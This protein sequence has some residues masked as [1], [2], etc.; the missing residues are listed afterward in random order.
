VA[1]WSLLTV[2]LASSAL[3]YSLVSPTYSHAASML[4]VGA[5]FAYWVATMDR[6]T[7]GRYARLGALAGF[8]TLVRW[9]DAVFLVVP[10][11]DAIWNWRTERTRRAVASALL[12]LAAC[13]AAALA[14]FT[15][16]L[17]VWRTLYGSWLAM[18]QGSEWMQ[19]TR[20]HL[21]DVLISDWHGL[22]TWTP[23]IALS[24][25]GLLPLARR[26]PRIGA[27]AVAA[28]LVSWYANAAVIEWWAGE[29]YGA[30]RF[31]SCMP[32]FV[33]G[34]AALAERWH[35]HPRVLIGAGGALVALNLLLLLQ[36]Q[37]FM[38]GLRDIAPYPRGVWG[39]ALARFVTP[40]EFVRWW[41]ER[42]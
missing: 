38:H 27:A 26:H 35:D 39:L 10:L 13:G 18:P 21:G 29:A 9:Q 17:L 6:Q 42:A 5:F 40:F 31:V 12:N 1:V 11:V 36:Y 22:L 30:R 19:W 4:A 16:Q 8:V 28:F 14:V 41:W 15:P 25:A 33:L 34:L 37:L 32:I 7:P 20:P 2:W 23:V 3:Y 24:L